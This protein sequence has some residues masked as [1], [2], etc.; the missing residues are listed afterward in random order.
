M[1]YRIADVFVGVKVLLQTVM[2]GSLRRSGSRYVSSI[3]GISR[4]GVTLAQLRWN[5]NGLTGLGVNHVP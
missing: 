2:E 3:G 1:T 4:R 5:T